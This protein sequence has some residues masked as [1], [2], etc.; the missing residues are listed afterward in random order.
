M[1]CE[2]EI[3]HKRYRYIVSRQFIFSVT[4]GVHDHFRGPCQIFNV[5]CIAIIVQLDTETVFEVNNMF[6]HIQSLHEQ[7]DIYINGF[8]IAQIKP[9]TFSTRCELL[10]GY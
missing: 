8:A 4:N 3:E 10:C 6:D 9:I 7:P 2:I 1:R 5:F